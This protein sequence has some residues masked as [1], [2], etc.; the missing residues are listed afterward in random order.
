MC[1]VTRGRLHECP[2][3]R[4]L[5]DPPERHAAPLAAAAAALQRAEQLLRVR[6]RQVAQRN[7]AGQEG[8]VRIK[9]ILL[10]LL[11]PT[12]CGRRCAFLRASG[13]GAAGQPASAES[14][15]R[16]LP[17]PRLPTCSAAALW[18]TESVAYLA[19]DSGS[20]TAPPQQKVPLAG[21]SCDRAS[22]SDSWWQRPPAAFGAQFSSSSSSSSVIVVPSSAAPARP[23]SGSAC[24]SLL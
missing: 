4:L 17:S 13:G 12:L 14:A 16:V 20:S 21:D 1:R 19:S 24:C 2:E 18:N 23:R 8:L 15:V 5:R 3:L 22:P 10:I 11:L 9:G 7:A 6:C